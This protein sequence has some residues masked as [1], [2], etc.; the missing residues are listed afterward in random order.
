MNTAIYLEK[1][2][3]MRQYILIRDVQFEFARA[4]QLHGSQVIADVPPRQSFMDN[5]I[6]KRRERNK[7]SLYCESWEPG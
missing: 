1:D 2:R 5:E 7:S 3:K 4:G 6:L